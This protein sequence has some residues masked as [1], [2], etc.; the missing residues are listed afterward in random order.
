MLTK[1]QIETFLGEFVSVGVQHLILDDKLFFYYGTLI[2]VDEQ[3]L[4]Q[5]TT[6]G[7]KL[8]PLAQVL[9]IHIDDRR[10]PW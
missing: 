1:E 8:V 10:Q 4:T 7:Y 9:D 5:K 2:K 6:T 3:V